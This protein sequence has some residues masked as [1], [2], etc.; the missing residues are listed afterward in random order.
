MVSYLHIKFYTKIYALGHEGASQIISRLNIAVFAPQAFEFPQLA[1]L[2][3]PSAGEVTDQPADQDHD[4][5][6]QQHEVG[7]GVHRRH[8]GTTK[9]TYN[10]QRHE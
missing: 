3:G 2:S 6:G 8:H 9:H 4:D 7:A 10:P 1:A 5:A